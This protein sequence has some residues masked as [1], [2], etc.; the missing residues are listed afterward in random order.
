MSKSSTIA[1]TLWE[2]GTAARE[3]F[4]IWWTL[5]NLSL[6][7]YYNVMNRPQYVDFFHASNIGHYRLFLLALSKIFDPNHTSRGI[8]GFKAALTSEGKIELVEYLEKQ[9]SPFNDRIE[10]VIKIRNKSL[11]HNDRE[12][13][14]YRV[15]EINRIRIDEI[16]ELIDVT[17]NTINFVL[18]NLGAGNL[19]F[20]DNLLEKATLNLLDVLSKGIN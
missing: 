12:L 18:R 8:N 17:C 20:D 2:E 6:P 16:H 9:L 11:V 15:Y 10:S 14:R 1:F 7:N 5:R 19:I 3:H 13:S 4:Q